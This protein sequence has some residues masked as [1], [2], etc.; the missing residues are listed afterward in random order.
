[1]AHISS[2]PMYATRIRCCGWVEDPIQN[3]LFL[4]WETYYPVCSAVAVYHSLVLLPSRPMSP[5]SGPGRAYPVIQTDTLHL[6]VASW[7]PVCHKESRLGVYPISH[8]TPSG[9]ASSRWMRTL[10]FAVWPSLQQI[11]YRKRLP[12]SRKDI[13]PSYLPFVCSTLIVLPLKQSNIDS[14]LFFTFKDGI[15]PVG[16][17]SLSDLP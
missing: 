11:E 14:S 10:R 5:A 1:M 2:C 6:T 8:L 9:S 17:I 4:V 16:D 12:F 13:S 7:R 15:Y 3:V